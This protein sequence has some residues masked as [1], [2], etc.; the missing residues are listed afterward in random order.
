MDELYETTSRVKSSYLQGDT[1]MPGH[2]YEAV[3]KAALYFYFELSFCVLLNTKLD[4]KQVI[5]ETFFRAKLL[6][7]TEESK[8]HTTQQ[9]QTFT[10]KKTQIQHKIKTN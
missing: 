3:M 8:P 5:L 1:T 4:T 9:E 2:W 6:A 10:Q 7:T